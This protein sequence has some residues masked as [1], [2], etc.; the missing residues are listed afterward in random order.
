MLKKC[1]FDTFF[2][3]A[4]FSSCALSHT[5]VMDIYPVPAVYWLEGID[6]PC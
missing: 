6:R 3:I 5:H 4:P 2:R 1:E